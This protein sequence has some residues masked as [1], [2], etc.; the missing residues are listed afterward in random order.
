MKPVIEVKDLGIE[1]YR[2]KKRRMSLREMI[3]QGRNT[4][5]KDTFWALRHVTFD[6]RPGDAVGIIGS[7]GGGKSTLLRM[8]AGVLIPDEGSVRVRGDVAPLIE[9]TGGFLGEL[10]ARENVYLAA[11][12]HG[13]TQAD[14]SARYDEIVDFA[15][16][17][18]KASM[19]MPFRHFSSGMQVRLAFSLITTLDKPIV[20]VDEVLAVGDRSFREQCYVR[21]E[22]MLS[23]GKTLFLVS[24]SEG[25]LRRFAQRGLYVREGRLVADGP[26]EDVIS[27]YNDYSDE[28]Q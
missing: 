12:L 18:V 8:I 14:I 22:K 25:D 2:G 28:H 19:E 1:F 20:L 23:G 17:Q 15:G 16:S 7:N 10:T 6:V 26:I 5:P 11:G 9:L 24:H 13:L 21:M 3:L 27:E 4:A